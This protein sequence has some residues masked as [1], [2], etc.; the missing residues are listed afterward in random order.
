[1]TQE[2]L[3]SKLKIYWV[4]LSILQNNTKNKKASAK[5]KSSLIS[6]LNSK[7]LNKLKLVRPKT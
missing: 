1:M 3:S 5:D 4:R 2:Q 6:T 7:A